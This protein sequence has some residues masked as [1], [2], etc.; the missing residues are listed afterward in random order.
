MLFSGT[1]ETVFYLDSHRTTSDL[2]FLAF[3]QGRFFI[4]P[5]IVSTLFTFSKQMELLT[6]HQ[7]PYK[8]NGIMFKKA[9]Y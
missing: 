7:P 3:L 4:T 5:Q 2:A 6:L 8:S 9:K 1:S